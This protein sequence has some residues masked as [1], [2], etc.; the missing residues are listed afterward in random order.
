MIWLNNVLNITNIN[1][2]Y[3]YILLDE[4]QDL[5]NAQRELFFKFK[6]LG[7]RYFF[8]GDKNQCLYNK[9]RYF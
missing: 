3:D 8:F 9:A 1:F 7:T 6:K 2:Q 5:S 4:C